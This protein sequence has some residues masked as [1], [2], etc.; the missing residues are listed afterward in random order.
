MKK[1]FVFLFLLL[2]PSFISASI[3]QNLY[4]GMVRNNSVKE[5]QQFLI[6]KGFLTGQA[7]GNFYSLTLSA[8]K[9]YQKSINLNGTG[10]VGPLTRQTINSDLLSSL[11]VKSTTETAPN[12]T[13]KTVSTPAVLTGSLNLSQSTSYS[14]QSVTAPQIKFKLAD[15]T[16]TNNTT[17]A[18][19][20][21]TIQVDLATGSNLYITNLY[22]K[23]LYLI[24]GNNLSAQ[25]GKTMVLD[26]VAHNNYWQINFQLAVGQTINLALYG[27]VNSSIPA[28][29]AIN[30]S[31]LVQGVSAVS[32]TSVSTNS[33]AVLTG[34][35]I[36]FGL[37]SLT[38]SQDNSNPLP[39][40]VAASQRVVAGKFQFTAAND[41]YTISELK[42]VI[43]NRQAPSIIS[44]G[45]LIDSATQLLLTQKSVAVTY[46]GKNYI[47]D[48]NVNIPISLNSSKSI[49]VSY[50]FNS[51]VSSN[52]TNMNFAPAL[53]YVKAINSGGTLADGSASDY[54]NMVALYNGITLPAG[55]VTVN[56]MYVFKSI[57]IFTA[58][59]T[60]A[61]ALTGLNLDLYTFSIT[62]DPAGDIAIK[63]IMFTIT[64][65]D[66]NISY[67][68]L[69]KFTLLKDGVNYS[70][71]VAIGTIVNNNFQEVTSNGAIGFGTNTVVVTFYPEETIPAGK[72]KTYTLKA[73]V[74][75]FVK[76]STLGLD[77]IST[78]GLSDA[79]TSNN[80][81]CLRMVF[82]SNIYGLAKTSS[83]FYV[84]NYNLLWSDKSSFSFSN[85]HNDTNGSSSNDWYN[86]FLVL[87]LPLPT[88]TITAQ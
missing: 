2:M 79:S 78:S 25:A 4:Y 58:N 24:Y 42:F 74:D 6:S 30:S 8:V 81:S 46:D 22:V 13:A 15:F 26:S 86:G 83:D 73:Y 35:N 45:V 54:S 21:K 20:L 57:P 12:S 60:S 5:L 76:S 9:K 65:T 40:I 17:E 39:R 27:D 56:A 7:T 51:N 23:N 63:Q 14:N 59:G 37:G 36:T 62:A 71:Q 75:N 50:D 69:N 52:S 19:N 34:Q 68:H 53:V 49:T 87:N 47:L 85:V 1:F 48:F 28:N 44:G 41:S 84:T 80:G 33:N 70:G 29:S 11:T 18:I 38:V 55:G 16:L 82:A 31:L 64:I 77:T 66:P 10:Y 3:D 88:Q 61:T 67:P 72:T 32:N 43:P